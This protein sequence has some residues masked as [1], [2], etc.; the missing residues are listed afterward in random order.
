LPRRRAPAGLGRDGRALWRSVV[1][2]IEQRGNDDTTFEL[3]PREF[4]LLEQACRVADRVTELEAIVEKRGLTTRGSTGQTV[5]HPAVAEIRQHRLALQR[6]LGS[7]GLDAGDDEKTGAASNHARR[8]AQAR[9]A[10]RDWDPQQLRVIG[11]RD[12]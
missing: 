1:D 11:G 12:T 2:D 4:A 9:W 8:A 7:I 3:D 5:I 10:R 6:I